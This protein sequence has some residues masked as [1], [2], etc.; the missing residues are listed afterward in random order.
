MIMIPAKFLMTGITAIGGGE[1]GYPA[2][3]LYRAVSRRRTLR[4]MTQ[5]GLGTNAMAHDGHKT[6]SPLPAICAKNLQFL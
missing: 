2:L 4:A 6:K 3:V 1:C 5:T